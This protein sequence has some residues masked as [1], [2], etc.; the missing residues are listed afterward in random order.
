MS[1]RMI[2]P[3]ERARRW[4][5]DCI[6]EGSVSNNA[7]LFQCHMDTAVPGIIKPELREDGYIILMGRQFLARMIKRALLRSLK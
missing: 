3:S 4:K 1:L 2:L 7:D 5:L 6:Y